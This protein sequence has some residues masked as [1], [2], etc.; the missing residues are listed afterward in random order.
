MMMIVVV[1][2]MM[3]MM[4]M[5]V[6]MMMVGASVVISQTEASGSA[7]K[8]R[9]LGSGASSCLTILTK[10]LRRGG[11]TEGGRIYEGSQGR[12]LDLWWLHIRREICNDS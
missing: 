8:Y 11:F 1:V 3:M 7:R 2:M 9:Q 10:R 4:M 12:M 6:V 5:V